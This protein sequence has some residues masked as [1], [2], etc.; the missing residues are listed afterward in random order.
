TRPG[1]ELSR[2]AARA[3]VPVPG[4][5][6][7]GGSILPGPVLA[8]A[9]PALPDMPQLPANPILPGSLSIAP[10]PSQVPDPAADSSLQTAQ[11][12]RPQPA[13]SS[14]GLGA[15]TVANA[16]SGPSSTIRGLPSLPP[17]A[18]ATVPGS[19]ALAPPPVDKPLPRIPDI[20]AT[21]LAAAPFEQDIGPR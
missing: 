13:Y 5:A 18:A 17:E 15:G 7:S 10:P 11:A 12:P 6:R 14:A 20:P 4:I 2:S 16:P 21:Q 19:S 1:G 9:S 3:D 8:S